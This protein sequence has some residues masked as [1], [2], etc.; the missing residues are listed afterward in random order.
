MDRRAAQL[1]AA[2]RFAHRLRHDSPH[3]SIVV[4]LVA[5]HARWRRCA[6][7]RRADMDKVIRHVFP[8]GGDGVSIRGG[9]GSLFRHD[10]AG[11]LRD[12][13]HLRLPGAAG[14]A[15]A[16]HR[17]GDA[18]RSPTTAR[19]TRSSVRKG[20]YFTPDPAFKGKKRELVA[21][22]YAYCAQ[23]PDRSAHPRAV[24]VAGRGQDRRA[25]RGWPEAAK[26]TGKFDYDAEDRRARDARPLHAAHPPEGHR[27]QPA[28]RAGARADVGGRA[29]GDRRVRRRGGPRDEP[30]PVGTGPYMLKQWVRSS[31]I[32]LE[33]NPISA[34]SVWDFKSND[35]ADAKLIAEMKGKKMPQVGRIEVSH[36]RGRPGAAARVPER[37]DRPR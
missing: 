24:G 5:R 22:D 12:A 11:D 36:H 8:G 23:A 35:P 6:G 7:L 33:A 17:R 9:A 25:R 32:V 10:R 27:L 2:D 31:K 19:R 15:G 30:I 14:Q 26:K 13:A 1:T 3:A 16:A 18:G 37:R 4:A 29:R 20:I 21:E 34:A 28:V